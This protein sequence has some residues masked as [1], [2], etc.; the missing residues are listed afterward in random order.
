MNSDNANVI[1][2]PPL[3]Y[4]PPVVAGLVA[5]FLWTPLQFF[6]ERWIGHAAGWPIIV[7]G[8]LLSA[9][10]IRTMF[11]AGQDPDPYGPS[12]AIVDTGPFARSR[13]PIYVSFSVVYV[14]IAFVANTVWLIIFM[15]VGIAL[16]HYGVIVREERYLERTLGDEYLQ[17]KA[18]VRRWL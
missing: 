18:R 15:P 8:I 2:P 16:L 6:P 5:E 4:L 10:S 1:A 12:T 7:A 14:G 13:N 17:Y 9:W 3:V 11:R